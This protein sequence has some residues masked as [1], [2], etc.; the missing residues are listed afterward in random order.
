VKYTKLEYSYTQ[1]NLLWKSFV[2][3]VFVIVL[4]TPLLLKKDMYLQV[5]DNETLLRED[6]LLIVDILCIFVTF[7]N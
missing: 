7:V 4:I 2:V 3:V 6:K 5:Y 1:Y